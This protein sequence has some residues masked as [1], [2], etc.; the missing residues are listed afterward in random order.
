MEVVI[1][2]A[3]ISHVDKI[4]EVLIS[5]ALWLEKEKGLCHWSRHISTWNE[6]FIIN[7]IN[8]PGNIML[9]ALYT[10]NV[11]GLVM[12]S[13]RAPEYHPQYSGKLPDTIRYISKLAVH[14]NC[15][16]QGIGSLLLYNAEQ[17]ILDSGASTA[18][19]DWYI[20]AQLNSFYKDRGYKQICED[21]QGI[22][23]EKTLI[24]EGF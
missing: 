24:G 14:P 12:V 19:L 4:V 18:A 22:F 10:N 21:T 11:V 17:H 16:G 9:V 13:S 23:A 15:I 20:P 3:S 5:A 2:E 6:E 8:S 1:Q 7:I